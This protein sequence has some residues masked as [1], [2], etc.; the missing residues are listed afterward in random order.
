M[1]QSNAQNVYL[2]IIFIFMAVINL[3]HIFLD[4][5]NIVLLF[6]L[7]NILYLYKKIGLIYEIITNTTIIFSFFCCSHYNKISKILQ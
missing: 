2:S 3:N 7:L 1:R 4:K 5:S 6:I